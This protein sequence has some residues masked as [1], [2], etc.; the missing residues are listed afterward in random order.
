MSCLCKTIKAGSEEER[1]N[2]KQ[3]VGPRTMPDPVGT[4]LS[5]AVPLAHRHS[6]D[7]TLNELNI[8]VSQA[9]SSYVTNTFFSMFLQGILL[10]HFSLSDYDGIHHPVA[11]V[12]P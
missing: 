4:L 9:P 3:V 1:E 6:Q 8:E 10:Q 7:D 12:T 5:K 2:K 11:I